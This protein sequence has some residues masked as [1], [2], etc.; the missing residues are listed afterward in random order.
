MMGLL[1]P[2]KAPP[3]CRK[4]V[5]VLSTRFFEPII[6]LDVSKISA[7]LEAKFPPHC[8]IIYLQRGISGDLNSVS[9][10]TLLCYAIPFGE[11]VNGFCFLIFAEKILT[12]SKET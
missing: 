2:A 1:V 10:K 3:L 11:S 7:Y 5:F 6:R 12:I 9:R 8:L 4:H